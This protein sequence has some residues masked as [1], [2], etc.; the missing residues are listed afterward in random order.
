MSSSWRLASS[1]VALFLAVLPFNARAQV[2]VQQVR[3]DLPAV[4]WISPA[5]ATLGQSA[6]VTLGGERLQDIKSILCAGGVELENVGEATG[7]QAKLRLKV[8]PSAKPGIYP[9]HVLCKAG[10]SNPRMLRIDAWPQLVEK[11]TAGD[12]NTPEKAQTITLP[13]SITGRLTA[14]DQDYFRFQA[15]AG[16]RLVFDIEA[17]RLGTPARP[18]LTLWDPN[19]R[20]LAKALS[21]PHDVA[22]DVRLVHTFRESG[23]YVL[24]LT[25][26]IYQ[27]G[28]FCGY[29][30]RIGEA[31]VITQMF[32]LGGRRGGKTGVT[33][34]GDGLQQPL[35]GNVDLTGDVRWQSRRL[36]VPGAPFPSPMLFSVG[37]YADHVE[38]EPNDKPDQ[39]ELLQMPIAI[40]GRVERPGDRDGFRFRAAAGAKLAVRVLAREL[41]SPLDPVIS[42]RDMKG[43]VLAT[44]D[45]SPAADRVPPVVRALLLPQTSDDP[46]LEFTA[47][48]EGEYF[49][50]IDDCY[51]HGGPGYAYRLEVAPPKPD[52]EL[53][54]QPGRST[55]PNAKQPQ[56]QQA[57]VMQQFS[58]QGAGS[59]S[60]D[61]GGRGTI[62]VKVVRRG[63]AGPIQLTAEGMPRGLTMNPAVIAAGQNQT[64]LV[65]QTSFD[66]DSSASF[67]RIYGTAE[68]S[69]Q[70]VTRQAEHPVVFAAMPGGAVA[71]H[72]LDAV[73]I[74]IS[75]QGAELVLRGD[76]AG[77]LAPGGKVRVKLSV[78]RREGTKGEVTVKAVSLPSGFT[79]PEVKIAEGKDTAEADLSAGGDVRPGQRSLQL[80]AALRVKGRNEPVVAIAP[81]SVDVQPLL[82]VEVATE[83]VD[84]VQGGK[85][86]VE[87]RL[88]RHAASA[89]PID[90]EFSGLPRGVTIGPAQIPDDAKT[91]TLMVQ[92]ARDAATS[93]IRRS[94]QIQPRTKLGKQSIELPT[95]R[96]GLK[97]TAK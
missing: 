74:G 25:D 18:V 85:A 14:A 80:E 44:A 92:A 48:A 71:Q 21:P 86:K 58:G 66:A 39:A 94:V 87:L 36:D 97:V 95:L 31:P 59:L 26:R 2:L 83:Q 38:R 75:G 84:L 51:S 29:Y 70:K 35:L 17:H 23:W 93:P 27:G 68:I 69:G 82:V 54:F 37:E 79:L 3:G 53:I 78:R 49:V 40:N 15:T 4:H 57:Q 19:G 28:D 50:T 13:C 63:Y 52:F 41:G 30:L 67:V 6:E 81:L 55:N 10:L 32:P 34:G 91:F 96:F 9:F 65:F 64:D 89:A 12:N 73:A 56:Q 1:G 22:P 5:G 45:D 16:Q 47:P 33:F 11:D 60:V 20:E 72:A 8:L 77:P 7:K 43:R 24:R 90:L 46:R 88:Q 42:I 62:V 61:R 76:A